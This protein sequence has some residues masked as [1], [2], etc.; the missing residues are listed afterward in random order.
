MAHLETCLGLFSLYGTRELNLAPTSQ[1]STPSLRGRVLCTS[2][3][4]LNTLD[5]QHDFELLIILPLPPQ[6]EVYRCALAQLLYTALRIQSI[7]S[8]VPG[9]DSTSPRVSAL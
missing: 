2:R 6:Y 8:C 7:T 4:A 9:Q 3:L 1:V 5:S